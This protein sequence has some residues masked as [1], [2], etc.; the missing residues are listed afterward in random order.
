MCIVFV[1]L[2]PLITEQFMFLLKHN[3]TGIESMDLL[4][5]NSNCNFQTTEKDVNI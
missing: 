2:F 3:S 1:I 4:T 5:K